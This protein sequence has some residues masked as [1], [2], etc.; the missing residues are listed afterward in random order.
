MHQHSRATSRQRCSSLG[1][2]TATDLTCMCTQQKHAHTH[3]PMR[4]GCAGRGET[5]TSAG[6]QQQQQQQWWCSA[7]S[8]HTGSGT[9]RGRS[10]SRGGRSGGGSSSSSTRQPVGLGWRVH[11]R[12]ARRH[13]FIGRVACTHVNCSVERRSVWSALKSERLKPCERQLVWQPLSWQ[14][15]SHS[16][17][18]LACSSKPACRSRAHHT[19]NNCMHAHASAAQRLPWAHGGRRQQATACYTDCA[20]ID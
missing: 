6:R 7:A 10:S 14:R 17:S 4:A 19:Q 11:R 2:V 18:S 5:G 1:V 12:S 13:R 9:G 20:I 16:R 15:S 3:T 8:R